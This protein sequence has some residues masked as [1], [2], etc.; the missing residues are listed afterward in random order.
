[1]LRLISKFSP[2][3]QTCILNKHTTMSSTCHKGFHHSSHSHS[4]SCHKVPGEMSDFTAK[5][6]NVTQM[7][8]PVAEMPLALSESTKEDKQGSYIFN[9][10]DTPQYYESSCAIALLCQDDKEYKSSRVMM[11]E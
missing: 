7:M 4:S 10:S 9:F 1:M 11:T 6:P 2:L 3:A 5:N 8:F